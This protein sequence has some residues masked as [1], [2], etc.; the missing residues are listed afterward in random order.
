[1]RTVAS[2]TRTAPF[3]FPLGAQFGTDNLVLHARGQRHRVTEFAGPLSI[4]TVVHGT[5]TWTVRGRPLTVDP[6]TFLVLGAGEPYSMEIDAPRP[7]E[8]ACIFFQHG[9]AE[10]VAR[11][12][13][14]PVIRTLDDPELPAPSLFDVCRLHSD[15]DH[16]IVASTQTLAGR[17]SRELQPSGFEEDFL[18]L[19]NRLLLLYDRI[20]ER[21]ARVPASKSSTREELLRRVERGREYIHSCVDGT[22]SLAEVARH[23]HLSRYH[24]HRIFTEAFQR[25]PHA[26]VTDVRL[27]RAYALLS[28]GLPVEQVSSEVGFASSSSFARRFKARYR[29]PP[30]AVR[31]G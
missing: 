16:A 17:C 30:G 18:V 27:A 9:F 10:R 5:V 29:R 19:S 20:R 11:D 4:K 13:T 26:Y 1:V 8:T 14:T 15:G 21:L 23:A 28:S 24:F 7:V 31:K 6:T 25:T 2:T 3:L 22:L 12:I